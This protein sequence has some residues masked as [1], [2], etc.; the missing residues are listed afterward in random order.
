[1]IL[2]KEQS[3]A[4]SRLGQDVCVVAGPGSGK[5]RVLVERFRRRVEQG[6]SPLRLLTVTF[7]EKAANELKERLARDF[8][9]NAL[10]REQIE[11]APVYTID[12][13]CANLLRRHAIEAGIDPQFDVLD[14]A[15]AQAELST[16]AE[17]AL[18][19]LLESN[20]AGMRALFEALDISDAIAGLA[21]VY[22]AMRLTAPGPRAG[23]ATAHASDAPFHE[24]LEALRGIARAAPRNWNQ[25]QLDALA[26]VREWARG[27]LALDAGRVTLDHFRALSA[28]DCDLRTLRRG[29]PVTALVKKVK[30]D[31]LDRAQQALAARY[32]EPQRALLWQALDRLDR[33]Y[34]ERKL[35]LNALDFADLEEQCLR[36][37]RDDDELRARVRADY[38]EVL[39]DELQ[40][41]N[42]LQASL[43]GMVRRPGRFFAVGDINQSIYGF[44]HADPSVFRAYRDGIEESGRPVDRLKDNYRS[45]APILLA[46]ESVLAGAPG[47]EPN[48]LVAKRQFASKADP[49]VEVIAAVGESAEE[50]AALEA[51]LVARRIRELEGALII[52]DKKARALRPAAFADMVV[53]VRNVNALPPIEQAFDELRI[54]YL[55]TRGKHFY[56]GREVTDL[57]HL[58][59]VIAN[60]RDE[61]SM[62]AVLRSPLVGVGADT[63][64]RLKQRGNL[65]KAV[66]DLEPGFEAEEIERLLAFRDLLAGL[67]ARADDVSPDRLLASAMDASDYEST[68]APRLRSNV[69][70]LL[71]GLREAFARRPQ[72]LSRLVERLEF[73]RDSDP[74]EPAAPP[75]DSANAV[76]LMT[77]HGAKGLEFPIVFLA[78]MH[79]GTA[80]DS[81]PL[82]F[83]PDAG[84]VA[85]WLDP[86]SGR[87]VKDLAYGHYSNEERRKA[88]E[89]EN[90]LL[91]V[92]MTRAE[93]HLVLS[94]AKNSRSVRNWAERVAGA[95]RLDLVAADEPCVLDCA[96]FRARFLC[97]DHCEPSPAAD[98]QAAPPAPPLAVIEPPAASGQHDSSASVTSI[99][100]FE[101]CPRRYYLERY[102]GWRAERRAAPAFRDNR[103]HLGATD[104]G[105]QV[106]D[107]LA[108][109]PVEKAAG[110]AVELAGRF[111][112]SEL[113]R[114]AEAAARVEREFDFLVAIGD[115]LIEGRIDLWFEEGG[116]LVIVDYKTDDVDAAGAAERA[117]S[118]A[119]QL[120]LYALALERFTGRLP[121]RAVLH[122]LRPDAVVPV[123]LAA[124]DLAAARE[125][126]RRFARAQDEVDFPK[127]EGEH[128]R[129]CSYCGGL[130][131]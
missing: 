50:A 8:A 13:F 44:R 25:S 100:Q 14:A 114:R 28:F 94:F 85:R 19:G 53:L 75:E 11:R 38:D 116:E 88:A 123:S 115:A 6:V 21:S 30:Q 37:L 73:L 102:L 89:E 5:T 48:P 95:L 57:V 103:E 128:C 81:P 17:E 34:R 7:T 108:N 32:F 59:R 82:S 120:R 97:A 92:A 55:I 51:R 90:R 63:L 24:L 104:L 131:R 117:A 78:A 99:A 119:L 43:I 23:G 2:S 29:D 56:E 49:S 36:L 15:E 47:V 16:A 122:Y 79:K 41:T 93:E 65:G 125:A 130:C 72:P 84:L 9:A 98:P 112:S 42:P 80:N 4:V 76:R 124:E 74:D 10:L 61:A 45:R 96:G 87:S 70:K 83:S 12:A 40:D 18:D 20:P 60:P 106:H 105:T 91:Y 58:L 107:L 77:V 54:P 67:R 26:G 66:V 127:R 46:A 35:A 129:G 121:G 86:V 62:A 110:L 71:A 3:A 118:Y 109:I 113:G 111:R 126:V 22:E 33:I 1:M 27:V 64:F 52:E 69:R 31:L 101:S 68:L 39:M